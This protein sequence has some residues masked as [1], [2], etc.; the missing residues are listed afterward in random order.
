M[1]YVRK[2]QAPTPLK[3]DH[4]FVVFYGRGIAIEEQNKVTNS[5]SC[6]IIEIILFVCLTLKVCLSRSPASQGLRRL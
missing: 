6:S 4:V 1:I 2:F 5:N 3:C